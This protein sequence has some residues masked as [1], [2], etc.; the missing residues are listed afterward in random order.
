LASRE[1]IQRKSFRWYGELTQLESHTENRNIKLDILIAPPSDKSLYQDFEKAVDVL[2]M[3]QSEHEIVLDS[4]F[5]KYLEKVEKTIR[6]LS[7]EW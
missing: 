4:E 6:P 5:D 1:S 7:L 3:I 2:N